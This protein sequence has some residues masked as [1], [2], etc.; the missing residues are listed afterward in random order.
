MFEVVTMKKLFKQ[1]TFVVYEDGTYQEIVG[2][3]KS[4]YFPDFADMFITLK[5]RGFKLA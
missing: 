3:E 4:D 2:G 1:Y 5:A